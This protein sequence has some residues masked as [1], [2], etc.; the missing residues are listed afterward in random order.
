MEDNLSDNEELNMSGEKEEVNGNDSDDNN[1]Y[2]DYSEGGW[3]QWFCQM[4]G[5]EFFIEI[6]EDYL[7][8]PMNLYGIGQQVKGFK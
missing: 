7:S 3:V 2:N 6:D 1:L 5:N 8:N 4:E